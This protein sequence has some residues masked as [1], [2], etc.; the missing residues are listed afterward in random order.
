MYP[1]NAQDD[2]GVL[3]SLGY[4]Q[5]LHRSWGAFT[6][7]TITISAMSVLTSI[8][9]SFAT[10]LTY[11]GP[12]VC[13]WGWLGVSFCM[14][15]I[16][17]GMAELSSAYP[18]SGGMY[19]WQFR[20]AGRTSGPFACW[21]TGWLNLLG[22]IAA[23][24]AVAFLCSGLISTMASMASTVGGAE[25]ITFTPAQDLGIYGAVIFLVALL[26]SC[27]LRVLTL[28][29]QAGGM[30][31]LAGVLLLVLIVPLMATTHQP[32]SWVFG[33]FESAQAESVGITNY[34][35]IA[36]LGLLLPAYSYTGMDGPC[37]MSEEVE[38]ASMHPPKAI[39]HGW[40]VM[41]VGGLSL[42]ISL[43]F[44]ITSIESVL[45]EDSAS[46]GN[47]VAQIMY[48]AAMQRFGTPHVGVGLM[49]VIIVGV[50]FCNVATMTY[51]SRILFCY[52]RDRAVPLS[53]LW[54]KVEPRTKS[55]IAA[56]WGVALAAFCLGLP[57]LGSYTA[58]NAILSLSTISLIIV[59]VSPITARITWGRN[60]F[61]PGPFNLGVWTY[62][63]GAISTLWALFS[64]V[65]FCL[66]IEMPVNTDN[67]NYAAA[68]FIGTCTISIGMFYFPVFG[69]Y[70]WFKGPAHT[71]DDDSAHDK[72][73]VAEG[74]K[75]V[76][77]GAAAASDARD[78][79]V[80]VDVCAA[81]K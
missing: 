31:H 28:C 10:G 72:Y 24:S 75:Q 79:D 36:I 12:A 37:H 27:G 3:R 76:A 33:H 58:F 42:I 51:V 65:V 53:S 25:H 34:F 32:A 11:G 54:L 55:P 62:P 2:E 19:Y 38:G 49:A 63:I 26:N 44:S 13:I 17:L 69:A 47:A 41:F 57:M 80:D 21:L 78:V 15:C 50:F 40:A 16:A 4:K 30:F 35:N 48:D 14:L 64:T 9:A 29:T 59:Y 61:T 66:P 60:H 23:V 81:A 6:T 52:S 71:V 56:V 7:T 1:L 70:K 43:L 5:V 68:A 20:L 74:G 39:L 67:L 18:T 8:S 73:E 22:Q 46:G 77:G 45:S